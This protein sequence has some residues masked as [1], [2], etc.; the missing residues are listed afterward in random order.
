MKINKKTKIIA[1]LGPSSDNAR[2]ISQMIKAGLDIVRLNFSHGDYTYHKKILQEVRKVSRNVKKPVSIIQDLQGP[3]IRIGDLYKE[4]IL[5]EE[6]NIFTL[7]TKQITGDENI[8]SIDYKKLP[9]D[10]KR[11]NHILIDD[12]KIRLEVTSTTKDEIRCRVIHGGFISPRK[13]V[14][15]QGTTLKINS[16]TEKDRQDIIWGIKNKV[17]F[18]AFSF[19][20]T[21]KDVIELRNI[22]SKHKADINIISKIETYSAIENIDAIIEKS[23]GI[24]V[25]RG[26]LAVEV[27]PEEVPMLQKMIIDKCTKA[28]KPAIVATQMLDSM[29]NSPTPTRAEVSDVANSILDGTDAVM[30]SNETAVGKYPVKTIET[31]TKIIIKTEALKPQ[32]KSLAEKVKSA[33]NKAIS[34]TDSITHHVIH[35]AQEV[36]AKIIVALTKSGYTARMTSRYN[37]RQPIIVMSPNSSTLRKITLSYGCFPYKIATFKYTAEAVETIKKVLK[38]ERIIKKGDVFIIVAG[39]PFGKTDS[40]NT[41]TVHKL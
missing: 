30:L 39:I 13:G 37:A 27:S 21:A 25:A 2:T 28:G 29:K 24:M 11:G 14:N 15:V 17:D 8:A 35:I 5:L 31:M 16:L 1:T 9:Y 26:D 3:K 19:V 12:G 10:V 40:T 32:H 34:T 23:D 7:T 38:K 33:E 4:K 20:K 6:G 36:G 18:I 41:L 22:L